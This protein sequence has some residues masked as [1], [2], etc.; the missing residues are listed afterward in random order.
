MLVFIIVRILLNDVV[1][2]DN[3]FLVL[4]FNYLEG[5]DIECFIYFSIFSIKIVIWDLVGV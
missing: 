4:G 1:F 2:I 3:F 5:R